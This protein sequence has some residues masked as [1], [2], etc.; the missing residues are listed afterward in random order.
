MDPGFPH[1]TS[2]W[3]EGPRGD[4]WIR[5]FH[6]L[7]GQLI[8]QCLRFFQVGG[9]EALGERAVDGCQQLAGLASPVLLEP[10]WGE[11]VAAR[12]S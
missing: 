2:P 4:E 5:F 11:L 7:S 8:E 10:L 1:G 12:N 6:S 9:V 3:A